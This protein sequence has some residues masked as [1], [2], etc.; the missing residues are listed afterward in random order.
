MTR[1]FCASALL[2][3]CII[4]LVTLSTSISVEAGTCMAS[5]KMSGKKPPTGQCNQENDS[6]C[7]KQ[8]LLYSIYKCSPQK[9]RDGGA[10]S[11]CDKQYHSDDE[12]V[13][14][15]SSG[16]YGNGNGVKAK[17]II[18]ESDSAMGCDSSHD[19]HPLCPNNV[20]DVSKAVRKALGVPE[21]D[22]S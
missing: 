15:L 4:F 12:L 8:G 22:L 21:I 7:C 2:L 17:V 14:A 19:Y 5:S 3:V 6:D 16:I 18:D 13:V 20:V 1:Q 11:E 9:N 10:P